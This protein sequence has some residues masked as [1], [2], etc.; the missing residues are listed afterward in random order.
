MISAPAEKLRMSS[1]VSMQKLITVSRLPRGPDDMGG[2]VRLSQDKVDRHMAAQTEL[3]QTNKGL[4]ES[5][6]LE[7]SYRAM[8]MTHASL[9]QDFENEQKNNKSARKLLV[10]D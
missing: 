6:S 1:P 5:M 9:R 4:A 10:K 3:A 7:M 2:S 8:A